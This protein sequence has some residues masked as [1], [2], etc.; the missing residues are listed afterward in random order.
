MKLRRPYKK[1]HT[2]HGV[3][4]LGFILQYRFITD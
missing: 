1:T 2:V 3:F 4:Q